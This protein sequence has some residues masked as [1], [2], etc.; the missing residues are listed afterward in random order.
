MC[1]FFNGIVSIIERIFHFQQ[2]N[3]PYFTLFRW[4]VKIMADD[5]SRVNM[6][7]IDTN[8]LPLKMNWNP[9]K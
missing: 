1:Y 3:R 5:N 4:K 9:R 6:Q 7:F 2:G 8:Q